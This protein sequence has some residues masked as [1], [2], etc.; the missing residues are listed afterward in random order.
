[1]LNPYSKTDHKNVNKRIVW[2]GASTRSGE[3][4]SWLTKSA[5]T[6]RKI[7][8][9]MCEPSIVKV[10]RQRGWRITQ[11]KVWNNFTDVFC[12]HF[13][14]VYLPVGYARLSPVAQCTGVAATIARGFLIY[15]GPSLSLSPLLHYALNCDWRSFF[16]FIFNHHLSFLPTVTR[17]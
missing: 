5:T 14:S 7:E 1:M 8:R 2:R 17:N 13:S 3:Q 11:L 6:E 15:S 10:K 4:W 16:G 12:F 9:Q